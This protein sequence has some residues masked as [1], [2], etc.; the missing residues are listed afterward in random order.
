[1][2]TSNSK[3]E[4]SLNHIPRKRLFILLSVLMFNTTGS[5]RI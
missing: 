4:S 1:M 2:N 5:E 3:N